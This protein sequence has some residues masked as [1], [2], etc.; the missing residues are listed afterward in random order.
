MAMG[1][2]TTVAAAH[3]LLFRVGLVWNLTPDFGPELGDRAWLQTYYF[4]RTFETALPNPSQAIVL[5]SSIVFFGIGTAAVNASLAASAIPP[6]IANMSVMGGRATDVALLAYNA[7]RLTPWLVVY[8]AGPRDFARRT[9]TDNPVFRTFY[10][11]SVDLPLAPRRTLHDHLDG[12]LKR[13]VAFYRYRAF[14]RGVGIR[15]ES[16]VA[17]RLAPTDAVAAVPAAGAAGPAAGETDDAHRYF[18]GGKISPQALALWQRWRVSRR[19]ADYLAYL[20]GSG[21]GDMAQRYLAMTASNVAPENNPHAAALEWMLRELRADGIRVVLAL[22]PENPITHQPDAGPYDHAAI[23]RTYA[24]YF[25]RLA[26]D[27]RVRFVDLHDLL[28]AED[29]TDFQHANVEGARKLSARMAEIVAEEWR[30]RR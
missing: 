22:C 26:R 20:Q 4:A 9:G 17:K 3:L 7:R 15:L 13:Y 28:D 19:F 25:T 23:S 21:E 14:L 8:C 10:D 18:M 16:E 12:W 29:F 2:V 6:R 30:A 11:S 5:G 1:W 27:D 24:A